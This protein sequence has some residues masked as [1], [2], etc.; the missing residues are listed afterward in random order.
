M[1]FF[2]LGKTPLLTHFMCRNFKLLTDCLET[3]SNLSGLNLDGEN[4]TAIG[5][6]TC[7]LSMY[8]FKSSMQSLLLLVR[9]IICFVHILHVS[10]WTFIPVLTCE[11][12]CEGKSSGK[13]PYETGDC[14]AYL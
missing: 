3:C 14:A 10:S 4:S 1:I 5:D 6:P 12:K 11:Q 7:Q 13:I 8:S 9:I 2:L